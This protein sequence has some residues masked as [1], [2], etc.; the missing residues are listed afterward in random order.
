MHFNIAWENEEVPTNGKVLAV[1]SDFY[2]AMPECVSALAVD[3]CI[4]YTDGK[5]V[6]SHLGCSVH[7]FQEHKTFKERRPGGAV[8]VRG[9]RA[10]PAGEEGRFD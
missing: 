10:L 3:G 5:P 8:R 4:S 7:W 6:A 2:N 1:A 9:R